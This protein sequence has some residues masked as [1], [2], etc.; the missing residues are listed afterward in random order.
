MADYRELEETLRKKAFR[1]P[2]MEAV[3]LRDER[4]KAADAIAALRERAE[5]AEAVN[6]QTTAAETRP[7]VETI[8][9][10]HIAS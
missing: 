10:S 1:G 5:R 4:W 8:L 9:Q 7:V 3:H 6:K 2:T